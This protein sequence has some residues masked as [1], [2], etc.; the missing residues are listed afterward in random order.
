[1]STTDPDDNFK[2]LVE[3]IMRIY[4]PMWFKIKVHHNA[5]DGP[6]NLMATIKAARNL[7][8]GVKKSLTPLSSEMLSMPIL[9][10]YCLP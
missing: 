5:E 3:F 7:S 9:K 6:G 10:T 1:M 2:M 4:A 8:E